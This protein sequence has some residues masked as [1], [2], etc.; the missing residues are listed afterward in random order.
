MFIDVK[1]MV[2][3]KGRRWGNGLEGHVREP[4]EVPEM[5]YTLIWVMVTWVWTCVKKVIKL[6]T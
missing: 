4:S 6:G 2:T 5:F 3:S 1:T